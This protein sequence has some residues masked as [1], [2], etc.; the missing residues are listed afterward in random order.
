MFAQYDP[1]GGLAEYRR[2]QKPQPK[3]DH[4]VTYTCSIGLEE[5]D[6]TKYPVI[7]MNVAADG[8]NSVKV[9][10]T[11]GQKENFGIDDG[12]HAKKTNAAI[13]TYNIRDEDGTNYGVIKDAKRSTSTFKLTGKKTTYK[14]HKVTS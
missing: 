6:E 14:C 12:L 4:K 9:K 7:K 2:R 3:K 11:N 10:W 5:N 8:F 1:W 13:S